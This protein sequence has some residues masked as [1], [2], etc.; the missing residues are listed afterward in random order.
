MYRK[1]LSNDEYCLIFD[2]DNVLIDTCKSFPWVIRT[3]IQWLWKFYL[4]RDVDCIAFTWEHF[5]CIKGFPQFNDDFDIAWSLVNIAAAKE[6]ASLND[7]FP[8]VE[9]LRDRLLNFKGN[10]IKAWLQESCGI[11]VPRDLTRRLCAELYYGNDEFKRITG[12]ETSM[13]KCSGF[14]KH[15]RPTITMDWKSFALPVGI[16]TGRYKGEMDLA[17][18]LLSWEDFPYEHTITGDSGVSKPSP[19]G[20]RILCRKLGDR[21]PV[22]F[23]DTESDRK[24]LENLGEG[25]FVAIGDVLANYRNRYP[26]L[27]SAL[28]ALGLN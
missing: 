10:D 12:M 15:E 4:K 27:K 24:T 2:V 9:E 6:A 19:E 18:R 1:F 20:L 16:Y 8:R 11:T 3:S 23:G 7:S 26:D 13:A 17:L 21:K 22:Y 28:S 25:V 14:W 5:G